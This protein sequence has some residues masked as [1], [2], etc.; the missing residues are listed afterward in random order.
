MTFFV[1]ISSSCKRL[2]SDCC[3]GRMEIK[4]LFACWRHFK[5]G[6]RN[7]LKTRRTYVYPIVDISFERTH[8]TW[9]QPDWTL[10]ERCVTGEMISWS[11][12]R[13]SAIPR[14]HVRSR[15]EPWRLRGGVSNVLSTISS[16]LD[17]FA[18][19]PLQWFRQAACK[20]DRT[21]YLVPLLT[22]KCVD[23]WTFAGTHCL[24]TSIDHC[25][26]AGH[27]K[28]CFSLL[29]CAL[30]VE[31][32]PCDWSVYYTMRRLQNY[33]SPFL[34]CVVNNSS[35][36]SSNSVCQDD[37][38]TPPRFDH[39]RTT[40]HESRFFTDGCLCP[41]LFLCD[42]RPVGPLSLMAVAIEHLYGASHY[43]LVAILLAPTMWSLRRQ[44]NRA[45]ACVS[46]SRSNYAYTVIADALLFKSSLFLGKCG[47]VG[48][49]VHIAS[50]ARKLSFYTELVVY[51]SKSPTTTVSVVGS[52]V[53]KIIDF[54]FDFVQFPRIYVGPES[55]CN[56][57][58]TLGALRDFPTID[59]WVIITDMNLHVGSTCMT[60]DS[61]QKI[62]LIRVD[63]DRNFS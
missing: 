60:G 45:P 49:R 5:G 58:R 26:T 11:Y 20:W 6:G 30:H 51:Y 13:S 54:P 40:V 28:R 56:S 31:M 37:I 62:S 12:V 16:H 39:I 52:I 43:A 42:F 48:V 38:L 3:H 2:L 36:F 1:F 44:L 55:V 4:H 29:F 25:N 50:D 59:T 18:F 41:F 21:T 15:T 53:F 61:Q 10:C 19:R 34:L 23:T 14:A 33:W 32:V 22:N 9:E 24:A 35:P 7:E 47:H 46:Y 8:F 57:Y 17:H 27:E 63:S